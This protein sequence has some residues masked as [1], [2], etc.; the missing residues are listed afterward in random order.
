[1][2]EESFAIVVPM[3]NEESG[4]L[5]CIQEIIDVLRNFP[6]RTQLILID[7]GSSD[8]TGRILRQAKEKFEELTIITHDRNLGYGAALQTGGHAALQQE[9]E[10][11]VFMDSDLTNNPG[12][13]SCLID[14]L[15][16]GYDIVKASRYI[17]GGGVK[18]VPAWRYWVSRIGNLIARWLYGLPIRDCTNGF[19]AVR[20]NVFNRMDLRERG[21]A[22]IMEELYWAKFLRAKVF[23]VPYVLTSRPETL[24]PSSFQYHPQVLYRYL[25]YPLLAFLGL[26]PSRMRL[27]NCEKN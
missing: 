5:R 9:Y 10:Y 25:K 14:R 20:T 4:A 17:A 23:E 2:S 11:V 12:F 16:N 26:A 27:K 13:I 19:R 8:A 7:D 18:G 21:F 6:Q 15:E 1:V 24:R 3:F 22:V